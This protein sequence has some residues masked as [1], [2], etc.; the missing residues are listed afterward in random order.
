MQSLYEGG[1]GTVLIR[2]GREGG[3]RLWVSVHLL[4]PKSWHRL[5]ASRWREHLSLCTL[6]PQ[7]TPRNQ[8]A[9]ASAD[10][11]G[12]VTCFFYGVLAR[13]KRCLDIAAG[14]SMPEFLIELL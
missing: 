1:S 4:V 8:K 11:M 6:K 9:T 5:S 14:H 12:P 13:W 10:V 2:M 3:L 7:G